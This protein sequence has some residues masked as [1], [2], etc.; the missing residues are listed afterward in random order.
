MK[1]IR[2]EVFPRLEIANG[3]FARLCPHRGGAVD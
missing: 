2:D 1:M 3:F